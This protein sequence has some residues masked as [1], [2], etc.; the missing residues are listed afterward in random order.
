MRWPSPWLL[1]GSAAFLLVSCVGEAETSAPTTA[2]RPAPSFSGDG[3]SRFC[4][5]IAAPASGTVPDPFQPGIEPAEVER[6]MRGLRRRFDEL[7]ALAPVELADELGALARA[8]GRLDET[9][10]SHGY[11][12]AAAGAAGEDLSAFDAPEFEE[13]ADRLEAYREQVCG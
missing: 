7:V 5:A 9:L 10:A 4:A 13:T 3:G 6:R 2:A 8:L 11:D 12:L 1:L